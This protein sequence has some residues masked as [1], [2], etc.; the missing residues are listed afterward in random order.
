MELTLGNHIFV[1]KGRV[2]L[3]GD[4]RDVAVKSQHRMAVWEWCDKNKIKLEYQGTLDRTDLWR[5]KDDQ[6][7]SWFILRWA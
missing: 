7:R 1:Q 6:Q 4:E 2:A 3:V 5:V